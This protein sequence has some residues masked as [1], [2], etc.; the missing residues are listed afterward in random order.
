MQQRLNFSYLKRTKRAEFSFWMYLQWEERAFRCSGLHSCLWFPKNS[1]HRGGS[2]P[3]EDFIR[4]RNRLSDMK[5]H[6]EQTHTCG[7]AVRAPCKPGQP[8]PL[9]S[10]SWREGTPALRL[11]DPETPLTSAQSVWRLAPWL[12]LFL[13]GPFLISQIIWAHISGLNK[14]QHTQLQ[15]CNALRV[16]KAK[17]DIYWWSRALHDFISLRFSVIMHYVIH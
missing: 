2:L 11:I 5:R 15:Q 10:W 16:C 17:S 1:K 12:D 14:R 9:V 6:V 3:H 7:G 4:R 13:L 8:S